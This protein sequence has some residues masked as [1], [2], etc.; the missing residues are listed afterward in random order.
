[1]R[2]KALLLVAMLAGL[3]LLP[4]PGRGDA[5]GGPL[6]LYEK[7][8]G[9]TFTLKPG[10]RLILYLRNPQ[11]G[12]YNLKEVIFDMAVLKLVAHQKL[13]PKPSPRPLVGDF[14]Q[15]FYEWEAVGNG[16]TDI[17]ITISRPWEKRRQRNTGG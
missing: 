17:R 10:G 12:G 9:S 14:G 16:S 2:K 4:L 5:A 7:D 3:T 11:S 13:P 1:M 15:F 8:R 6:T